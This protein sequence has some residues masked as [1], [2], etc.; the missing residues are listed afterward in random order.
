MKLADVD[1][2]DEAVRRTARTRLDDIASERLQF[3]R[4]RGV[5][6][7]NP[8]LLQKHQEEA[9]QAREF[10]DFYHPLFARVTGLESGMK[11]LAKFARE[12]ERIQ[13]LT[14]RPDKTRDL[15][16]MV[17]EK[18]GDCETYAGVFKRLAEVMG[19][20]DVGLHHM[21][22]AMS[23]PRAEIPGA[24][25]SSCSDRI[26]FARH[27]ILECRDAE[28]RVE[29]FDPVFGR[30]V[31]PEFYGEDLDRYLKREAPVV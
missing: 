25:S 17:T 30:A 22:K 21:D 3:V 6:S 14:Y 28:N 18:D 4:S 16:E 26:E 27:T 7:R 10:A 13:L 19:V 2:R 31:D 15:F 5:S 11:L 12:N 20:E 24:T 1:A 23:V 8:V 9:R 29:H